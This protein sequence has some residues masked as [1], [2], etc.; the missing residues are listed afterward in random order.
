MGDEHLFG[1]RLR[2]VLRDLRREH[3]RDCPGKTV[4]ASVFDMLEDPGYNACDR[5]KQHGKVSDRKRMLKIIIFFNGF[6]ICR[7]LCV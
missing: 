5:K 1:N 2:G 6:G 7:V 4:N 3:F